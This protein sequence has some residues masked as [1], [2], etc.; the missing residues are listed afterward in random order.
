MAFILYG[1]QTQNVIFWIPVHEIQILGIEPWKKE[2]VLDRI[3]KVEKLLTNN[4]MYQS[5]Q[6]RYFSS[7]ACLK[8][9]EGKI[10]FF[11]WENS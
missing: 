8:N 1:Q 2:S 5:R 9:S 6:T 10:P 3:A 4:I 11:G 7:N